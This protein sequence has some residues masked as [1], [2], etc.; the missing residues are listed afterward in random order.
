MEGM[1]AVIEVFYQRLPEDIGQYA[2]QALSPTT[3]A[4]L[5]KLNTRLNEQRDRIV[6]QFRLAYPM[7]PEQRASYAGTRKAEAS[8]DRVDVEQIDDSIRRTIVAQ[9][10]DEAL[11]PLPHEFNRHYNALLKNDYTE[12]AHPYRLESVLMYWPTSS[13][14]SASQP[15]CACS[16]ARPWAAHS[17]HRLPH[18]L[19]H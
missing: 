17:T 4:A 2:D 3:R 19:P 7:Y 1:R 15:T 5:A 6:Q 14:R 8:M 11:A 18:S 10:I 9:R 16:A 13:R 12:V